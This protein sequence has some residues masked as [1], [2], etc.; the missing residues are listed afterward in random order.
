MFERNSRSPLLANAKRA[1]ELFPRTGEVFVNHTGEDIETK[2]ALTYFLEAGCPQAFIEFLLTPNSEWNTDSTS[3]DNPYNHDLQSIRKRMLALVTPVYELANGSLDHIY[4]EGF[5]R[6]DK[7]HIDKVVGYTKSLLRKKRT[8]N[9]IKNR[10]VIAA[11]AHDMGN[12]FSRELHSFISARML[13]K[14]LPGVASKPKEWHIIRRAIQLHTEDVAIPF[15]QSLKLEEC[16]TVEERYAKIVEHF[17]IEALALIIADKID[18]GSHRVSL[19]P[20]DKE[21]IDNDRH[22]E[23]NLLGSTDSFNIVDTTF[24]WNLKFDAGVPLDEELDHFSKSRTSNRT[25]PKR[26]M[27]SKKTHELHR[28]EF[29]PIPHFDSWKSLFWNLYYKRLYL[30]VISIFA[31]YENLDTIEIKIS[32]TSD[33]PEG[34]SGE[35]TTYTIERGKVNNFFDIMALKVIPKRKREKMRTEG[36]NLVGSFGAL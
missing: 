25:G 28:N 8:S 24:H 7:R 2:R 21:A 10:A 9:K 18:V 16:T 23:V 32:D 15:L 11:R 22:L 14:M 6:H 29:Q 33:F 17:G 3:L 26:R 27:V 13:K 36:K 1:R 20:K 12:I 5:N 35:Q 31:L 19:K 4:K 30:T 34:V